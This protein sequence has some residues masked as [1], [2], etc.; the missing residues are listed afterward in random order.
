MVCVKQSCAIHKSERIRKLSFKIMILEQFHTDGQ[1]PYLLAFFAKKCTIKK[2]TK[3][4]TDAL[5]S[6]INI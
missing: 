1:K 6:K 2:Q 5:L 4:W 3:P